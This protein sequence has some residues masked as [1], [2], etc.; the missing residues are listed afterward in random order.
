MD[1]RPSYP[2]PTDRTELRP[3]RRGDAPALAAYRGRPEVC[4]F[5][6]FEPM[7]VDEVLRRL[8]GDWA[9]TVLDTEGQALFLGVELRA[10]GTVV[11][12]LMLRWDSFRDR[13]GEIGYVFNPEYAGHGLATEAAHALLHLAFDQL[14]L[15]RVV[16]RVDARNRRSAL[17]AARLGMRQEAHLVENEWFKGA[18]SDELDF[19]LLSSEWESMHRARGSHPGTGSG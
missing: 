2:V 12:D 15:H 1:L 11:G 6:P 19:A 3:L 14:R 8:E 16:A 17:L 9:R 4:R 18:W 10:T 5:V 7:G 13:G